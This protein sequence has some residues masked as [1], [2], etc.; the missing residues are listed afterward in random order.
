MSIANVPYVDP[1]RVG[2]GTQTDG[3]A[4]MP[5]GLHDFLGWA[6][7][8]IGFAYT[9]EVYKGPASW[10]DGSIPVAKSQRL[11]EAWRLRNA[12]R[13][14]KDEFLAVVRKLEEKMAEEIGGTA[15]IDPV[16]PWLAEPAEPDPGQS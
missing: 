4:W 12:L 10:G 8:D 5:A 1:T 3:L 7:G 2:A 11:M 13:E 9:Y 16:P 6:T 14:V 15:V